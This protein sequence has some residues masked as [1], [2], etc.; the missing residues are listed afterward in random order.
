MPAKGSNTKAGS[1]LDKAR[2]AH[3][4]K[5]ANEPTKGDVTATCCPDTS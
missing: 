2:V 3:L 1:K 5:Q 4:G